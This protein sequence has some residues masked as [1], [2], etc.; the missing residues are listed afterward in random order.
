MS[1][2]PSKSNSAS[3]RV[4]A[5]SNAGKGRSNNMLWVGIIAV[6]MVVGVIA[7][8]ATRGGGS[9]GGGAASPSGGTVVPN[10]NLDYGPV[11]VSG[12]GLSQI[13]TAGPDTAIGQ[14]VP[15][16]AGAQF[17]GA[18]LNITGDGQPMVIIVL[19]HWCGFCQKE[20]PLVQKW[21][22]ADGMP[23]D[24]KLLAVATSNSSAKPNFPPA[25]WLRREKWSVPTIV[26]DKDNTAG[27]AFGVS[28]FPYFLVVNKE[29]KVVYR[30]SGM[31]TE[32]EFYAILQA[33]RTGQALGA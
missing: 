15:T 6:V 16:V 12:A 33:A 4:R 18:Q 9:P 27:N 25:D 14:T 29:G 17:D 21:L 13:P 32:A 11:Q 3:Q 7:V 1:N 24:V 23:T 28:G 20:V 10:G 31:K 8:V 5:A 26:D 22:N 19:A 30:T 2:R